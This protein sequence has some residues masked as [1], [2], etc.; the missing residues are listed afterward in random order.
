MN[1]KEEFFGKTINGSNKIN[2]LIEKGK[3]AKKEKIKQGW[4]ETVYGLLPQK[5]IEAGGFIW[6]TEKKPVTLKDGTVALI[7]RGYDTIPV[8]SYMAEYNDGKTQKGSKYIGPS[9]KFLAWREKKKQF[10]QSKKVDSYIDEE[11]IGQGSDVEQ[12]VRAQGLEQRTL[13]PDEID[14]SKIPF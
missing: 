2:E 7:E 8:Q 6:S 13:P 4:K 1:S 3:Q 9:Q 11:M 5:E 10:K 12:S 14:V